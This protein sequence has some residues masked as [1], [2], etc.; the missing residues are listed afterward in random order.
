VDSTARTRISRLPERGRSDRAQLD[1]LLDEVHVVHVGL[2][3]D[4][5][6]LV[7]PTAAARD[8]DRLLVHG[9]TGSAWMRRLAAGVESCV[10]VTALDAVV[11][12]RSGFESSFRYRSAVLFGRFEPVEGVDKD[13]ALD[14]LVDALI[15]G[16]VAEV[17]RPTRREL[18]ATLVLGMP[19]EE[20]SL[21]VSDEWPEDP[22]EDVEGPAW[23]G[24]V[25]VRTT[26]GDSIPAPDLRAG[27]PEPESVRTLRRRSGYAP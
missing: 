1:A 7:V 10:T 16:R 18:S 9:S 20:W 2:V 15:P 12:A 6:P 11:V 26:Y 4:G 19:I 5:S 27:I 24:V 14:V 13:R 8:G 17:R 3:V 23:A 21:K 22:Q 25:P